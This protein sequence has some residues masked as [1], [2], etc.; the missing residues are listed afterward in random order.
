MLLGFISIVHALRAYNVFLALHFVSD[1][2][3][4]GHIDVKVT[5]IEIRVV[6][7]DLAQFSDRSVT[8]GSVG[9]IIFYLSANWEPDAPGNLFVFNRAAAG[10]PS[11]FVVVLL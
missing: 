9:A 8:N 4:L 3:S 5:C 2:R 1:C 6:Y 11:L 10:K 7:P